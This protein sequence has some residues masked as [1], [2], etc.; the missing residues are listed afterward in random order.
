[1]NRAS[2]LFSHLSLFPPAA[3]GQEPTIEE[4]SARIRRSVVVITHDDR[5]G[6]PAGT[7]SGF[8][9]SN[10]GLI[11]TCAHVI[12]ESRPLTVR[13]DDGREHKVTAIHAWDAKLDLAVLRIDA[14]DLE[15]ITLAEADSLPQG[16]DV[17]AMGAPHGLAFSVVRGVVSALRDIDDIALIQIAIPGVTV[18][19]RNASCRLV[20]SSLSFFFTAALSDQRFWVMPGLK[21]QWPSS[22]ASTAGDLPA[23]SLPLRR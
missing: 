10:D 3:S 18:E 12:G 6:G 21:S 14:G 15:P 19:A 17:I 23:P 7:G 22:D 1:M 9:V 20:I 11:A 2:A 4:L 13:F 5:E 16:A 8:V